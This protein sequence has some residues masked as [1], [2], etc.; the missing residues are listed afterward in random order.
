MTHIVRSP[1]YFTCSQ[2][3]ERYDSVLN[4]LLVS[5][6]WCICLIVLEAIEKEMV[7]DV[8]IVPFVGV[9]R[10]LDLPIGDVFILVS[11][12]FCDEWCLCGCAL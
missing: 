11:K 10:W 8:Q 9:H 6:V 5:V 7:V 2:F 1:T 12:H 3:Y 4:Y